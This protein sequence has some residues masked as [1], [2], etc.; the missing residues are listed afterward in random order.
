H[1][2]T[3][4]LQE[5]RYSSR[6]SGE[7]FFL[8]EH[9]V[10]GR[11]VLPGVAQLEMAREAVARASGGH[12]AL[13]TFGIRL[14]DVIFAR[15][16]VV[17]PDETPQV[18]ITLQPQDGG[19][20]G[21]EIYAGDGDPSQTYSQG[22]ATLEPIAAP[23]VIDLQALKR[24]CTRTLDAAACYA[25]FDNI[26]MA[27]GPRMRAVQ[28]F[29]VGPA[30][31]VARL[32]LAQDLRHDA[33]DFGL[34]PSLIDAALHVSV[35]M[36]LGDDG[37]PATGTLTRMALPFAV[38]EVRL[39]AR[40][41]FDAWAVARRRAQGT[42]SDAV[43]KLD[44]DIVDDDG[45]LCATV[46]GL[47]ARTG[48]DAAEGETPAV[49]T[50]EERWSEQ[51]LAEERRAATTGRVVC[52]VTG[53]LQQ[54]VVEA[55]LPAGESMA[56]V[57]HTD[58]ADMA[59]ALRRVSEA[60]GG[61]DAVLYLR[62]L[63]DREALRDHAAVATLV[64]AIA[65]AGVA[66]GR[67]LLA[68]PC[69]STM[70]R[71]HADAWLG[72]ERSL[73]QVLPATQV[74]VIAGS[75][76][77]GQGDATT[78]RWMQRLQAERLAPSLRSS[79]YD[80]D[81]RQVLD[82]APVALAT[83]A[84]TLRQGGHYL[85]T[86]GLGGLGLL[87]ARHLS[88]AH[89]A[90]ITLTGRSPLDADRQALLNGLGHQAIYLQAD[91]CERQQMA[92]ALAW[93]QTRFGPLHGVIHA[94]GVASRQ[95][96]L[97]AT[98]ADFEASLGPKIGGT[99]VLESLLQ[100]QALDFL[101]H[102]SS[103]SA[104]LG[105]LGLCSYA[106]GNRYQAARARWSQGSSWRTVAIGWPL[107]A[108]GGMKV[109]DDYATQRYL[110]SSGQV[111]LDA[112]RG[113]ALFEQLLGQPCTQ[114]LVLLGQRGRIERLLRAM[115]WLPPVE[116]IP[117]PR[118][119]QPAPEA[120]AVD[121]EGIDRKAAHLLARLLSQTLGVAENRIDPQAPL[122]QYGI[123]S[124][125]VMELTNALERSF[126]PLPKTL[127]YE[128]QTLEALA[129]Y[130]QHKHAA[131][132]AALVGT[133]A[134][135]PQQ[136]HPQQPLLQAATRKAAK[137]FA[138]P[139]PV[140]PSPQSPPKHAALDIAVVGLSGRYP[141]APDLQAYWDNLAQGLNCITEVPLDRWDHSRY[142]DTERGKPGKTYSKWGGFIDGVAEFDPQFFNI[143]PREAA[144]MDPQERLFLQCAHATLEDAGYTREQLAARHQ[145]SG[146]PGNVG[147]F[148]GVMFQEYPL[149]GAQSQVVAG[150][151]YAI[152]TNTSSI[153][154]RVSY[155][156][157]FHGPSMAV[158]TMCSSSLTAIH[159][160][161]QSLA[162]G[163][164]EV[165]LAGGVNLSVHPNK[166]LALSQGQF[167]SSEGLCRSF[168]AGGDGYVPGEGVGAVLLKPLAQALEDGDR[169]Y[170]VIKGS[171]INHGGKTNG[172]TVPNP[173]AHASVVAQALKVSGVHPRAISYIEAHGTGT[174]LGDPIEIAGLT[175]AFEAHTTDR[176]YC[177]IGSAK[178][179]VGHCEA[180]AGIAG[181]SKVL[182]QMQHRKITRSLHSAALNPNID[183]ASTPFRVQ[184]LTSDW[185]RPVL[186][187]QEQPRIAGLSSFGAGGSNAHLVIEEHTDERPGVAPG[188]AVVV[189]LSARNDERLKAQA[190]Q[191][192]DALQQ[193]PQP[194]P[195]VA[196]TLQVGREAMEVR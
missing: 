119:A 67:L 170:G 127:F 152:G 29:H 88:A 59:Q 155:W 80:G 4:D 120:L 114:P 168:G 16:I 18:H 148:V 156:C 99:A 42:G 13:S 68:A 96:V 36:D 79:H 118:P 188:H 24:D 105:D 187:G 17:G 101:C 173:Q 15:P 117:D 30:G 90:R 38:E 111:A 147:V 123:D 27:Y 81:R 97:Q 78:T 8:R 60:H 176:Q 23:Q 143:T 139:V 193:N 32:S 2:N 149:Y 136:P 5:Q 190:R 14:H 58:H 165:A 25:V 183:F 39:L 164:C 94:A 107:W 125:M 50:Y 140:V 83:S 76:A 177:A 11:R 146:M 10:H 72:F 44:V 142:F 31:V 21:F 7:E 130:F 161:C 40:V 9:V 115:Q 49:L 91:V 22:S 129:R 191:L 171:A 95:Q 137:R 102:F 116:P 162:S 163:G 75:E 55:A 106:V 89:G 113:C 169:I 37:Q 35:G 43:Q 85:I 141:N 104:V 179:I 133:P 71:C 121:A 33:S 77:Q 154:N 160:A 98:A 73:Q 56:F 122:G 112:V 92:D 157:N 110:A 47:V 159:L 184:Q 186:D 180:A 181:L 189:V 166:Y 175:H 109:G 132:L 178:S 34:H 87:M 131:S 194:L 57:H 70:D 192:R 26:G 128:H 172:Y 69:A 63:A 138:A 158:D 19:A 134:V 3:S 196:Y 62:A 145:A 135:A 20:I 41:P 65:G 82:L 150:E 174:A 28:E 144:A 103:A 153:A 151:P 86:G 124:V 167:F 54:A 45:R 93:A 185:D 126:G 195:D 61:I 12:E 100:G 108:D 52:V 1:T 46:R 6:F 182:L 53:A 74:A 51:P 84:P 48:A 66:C 64:K